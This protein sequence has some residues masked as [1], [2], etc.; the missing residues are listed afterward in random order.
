MSTAWLQARYADAALSEATSDAHA[1]LDALVSVGQ[2]WYAINFSYPVFK[3]DQTRHKPGYYRLAWGGQGH[4]APYLDV[5]PNHR[6]IEKGKYTASLTALAAAKRRGDR[7]PER[8]TDAD[9]S[10]ARS[11]DAA[12]RGARA[13]S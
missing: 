13:V 1:A 6:A 12:D 7:A 10:G 5:V 3:E 9:G 2:T 4:L 8:A 11:R